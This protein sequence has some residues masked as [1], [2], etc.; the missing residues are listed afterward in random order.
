VMK[1]AEGIITDENGELFQKCITELE[2]E[3]SWLRATAAKLQGSVD[4][5]GETIA[6]LQRA[7]D[8][9]IEDYNMLLEGNKSLLAERNALRDPSEDLKSELTKT[10]AS[11]AE[12][13]AALEARIKSA[14]AHSM[15][16]A[17]TGKNAYTILKKNLSMTW[18]SCAH[19]M[20]ATFKALEVC[21]HRCL[22][23][24]PRS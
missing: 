2:M 23:V 5:S 16:V 24:S 9:G 14:E 22:K 10:H 20:N 12:G 19:Y 15:E 6:T 1:V 3:N 7:V 11:A 13:I 8:A 18:W 21:A 17:A 4:S